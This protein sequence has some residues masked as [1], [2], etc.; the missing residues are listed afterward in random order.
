MKYVPPSCVCLPELQK[1]DI[2]NRLLPTI[3]RVMG[4]LY[5]DQAQLIVLHNQSDKQ[6]VKIV[7]NVWFITKCG[8]G[9]YEDRLPTT[10]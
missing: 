2:P 10:K 1:M 3:Y 5:L 8:R 4:C 9:G 6:T 7:R